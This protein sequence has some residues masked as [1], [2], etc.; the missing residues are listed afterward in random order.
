MNPAQKSEKGKKLTKFIRPNNLINLKSIYNLT[1]FSENLKTKINI[2]ENEFTR[3]SIMK[4]QWKSYEREIYLLAAA[5][6]PG[7]ER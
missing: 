3:S 5:A 1:Y 7:F 6:W 2:Y 4:K